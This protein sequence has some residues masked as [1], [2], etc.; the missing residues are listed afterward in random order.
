[1]KSTET[2]I[3]PTIN[4]WF[5]Y[6]QG[7]TVKEKYTAPININVK[8]GNCRRSTPGRQTQ[9]ETIV[10]FVTHQSDI[11]GFMEMTCAHRINPRSGTEK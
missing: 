6:T 11:G 9:Y 8:T 1:M 10:I 7:L 5:K 3:R 2:I 4:N